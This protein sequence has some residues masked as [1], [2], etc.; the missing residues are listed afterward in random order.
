MHACKFE[1]EPGRLLALQR[2]GVLDPARE[3]DFDAIIA[4]VSQL[5]Q[6][7]V[8]GV[9]LIE[10]DRVWFHSVGWDQAENPRS[11]SFCD[12][13]IRSSQVMSVGDATRDRRFSAN[14][15]VTG[16]PGIRSYAGAPLTTPDGY[17]QGALCAVD[18][19]QRSFSPEQLGTL[20]KLSALVMQQLEL[21][22]LAHEDFLT[23][24][25]TRRAFTSAAERLIGGTAPATLVT[26]DIDHFKQVND[27]FGHGIGDRVLQAVAAECRTVLR[28]GDILGRLGGEEFGLLL[29]ATDA[30]VA[31]SCAERVRCAVE[32]L[33]RAEC[34]AVTASFGIASL[35][36]GDDVTSWLARADA[37]LYLA[38]ASGRNRC[39]L[40]PAAMAEAA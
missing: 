18:Y 5:F 24:V 30:D 19:V 2:Y 36:H 28:P 25:L 23:R 7:P 8:C 13:A 22:T 11:I 14:P 31:W 40:A 3:H 38:K 20:A 33:Q 26:F 15:L 1:D 6:V 12:H 9:S 37:A 10:Q 17:N 27:R 34:P 29:P 35:Q 21:R 4:I 39:M 16:D 32:D